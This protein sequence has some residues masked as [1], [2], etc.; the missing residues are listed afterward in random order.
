MV[1]GNCVNALPRAISFLPWLNLRTSLQ[2]AGVNALPRAISFL[3]SLGNLLLPAVACVNA[4]PRAISFLPL[5]PGARS[6][7]GF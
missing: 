2:M 5:E 1:N 3:Q 4:L 6:T 7:S